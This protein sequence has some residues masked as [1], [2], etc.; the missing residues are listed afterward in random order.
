MRTLLP[1][2]LSCCILTPVVWGE[3]YRI[4]VSAGDY[5]REGT[6]VSFG[7]EG[8]PSGA[9]IVRDG[10]NDYPLQ[11]G[12]DGRAWFV[13]PALGKGEELDLK[14][15]RLLEPNPH[16]PW[17]EVLPE[18]GRLRLS[19]AGEPALFYQAAE[20]PFPREGL[21]PRI[22]RG[23]FLHPVLSPGGTVV[24]QSYPI[25]HPHHQ[26]VWAP[27]TRTR[28]EGRTPDF[29]NMQ[30]GTGK[31]EFVEVE[32]MW[33][34]PVVGGFRS[35][36]QFVD[37]S[38]EEPKVAL[39]EVWT[40]NLFHVGSGDDAY[41]LFEVEMFQ[42]CATESPLELPQHVYGGLGF[43]GRDEW[44]G[45][46][47]TFFLTSE[48]ET[49]RVKGQGT[50]TR[51]THV[52]GDVDGGRSGIAILGHPSNFRAPQP[53]RLHPREPFFCFAPSQLGDWAITPENPYRARYRFAV[54]DGEPNA[55]LIERLWLDFAYPPEVVIQ[56]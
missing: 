49:D 15:T 39:R 22:K 27:W 55:D 38:A 44:I 32:E 14:V 53:V 25:S 23:G 54:M 47:N 4:R 52:S 41:R 45:E 5:D 42:E 19:V 29:W 3:D 33:S 17:V 30:G 51:W 10:E 12:P 35:R 24:S 7:F 40:V 34:G 46:G 16:W 48:G 31:V 50:R 21:N 37:T 13:L 2:L 11:T 20:R 26:G 56:P 36:H 1:V 28:F 6:V 8:D 43:R 18:Q 9:W